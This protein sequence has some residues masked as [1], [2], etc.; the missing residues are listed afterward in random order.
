MSQRVSESRASRC[1]AG[2][3]SRTPVRI[4]RPTGRRIASAVSGSIQEVY[5]GATYGVR[6][7]GSAQGAVNHTTSRMISPKANAARK[8]NAN[9]TSADRSAILDALPRNDQFRLYSP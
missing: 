5:V 9:V 2:L 4:Q 8:K 1:N 3:A 7:R 6:A